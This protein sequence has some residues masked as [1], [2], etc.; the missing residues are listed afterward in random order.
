MSDDAPPAAV[1]ETPTDDRPQPQRRRPRR[2]RRRLRAVL[3]WAAGGYLLAAF[4]ATHLPMP[5]EVGVEIAY[6]D[7][8]VHAT[9]FAGLSLLI[10][11]WRVT[12]FDP[13]RRAAAIAFALCL[14]Y[15]TLDELSQTLVD[16]RKA[17]GWD[18]LADAVGALLGLATFFPLLRWWRRHG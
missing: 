1:A 6:F 13:P 2:W 16:S 12:R 7:K 9:I 3:P 10:A 15:G 11:A 14:V 4:T 18:L 8:L 17:D 5:K